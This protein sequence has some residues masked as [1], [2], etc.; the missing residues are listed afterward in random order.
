MTQGSDDS[1]DLTSVFLC[2]LCGYLSLRP[3]RLFFVCFAVKSF[4]LRP[5]RPF[6]ATSAF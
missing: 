5:L 4:S 6:S 3:S 2:V 1:I